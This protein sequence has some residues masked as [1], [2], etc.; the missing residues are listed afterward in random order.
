MIAPKSIVFTDWDG[1]V[2]LQDSNDLVTDL[3]GFGKEERGRLF[4]LM[5]DEK[6]SF[7]E[8]F[9]R[10][11]K[12]IS[13]N[14]YSVDYC[15]EV[16]LKNVKLDPGFKPFLMWCKSNEVPLYVISSGMEP[17]INALLQK[18]IGE[19]ADYIEI[20]ANDVKTDPNDKAK[21]DI[22]YRDETPFGHDKS[23]SI[24]K[25]LSTYGDNR[26]SAFYCGDGISD[27]S[28][29]K[30]CD[31]LFA[32]SGKDLTVFCDRHSIPYRE[33]HTFDDV[34][35]DIAAVTSGEKSVEDLVEGK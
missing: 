30:T 16:L 6:M 7:R 3:L 31:I 13:D 11:L 18:L 4:E 1:T 21:W 22:V 19:E 9:L 29:S 10:M 20:L 32:R 25:I 8:G 27:L 15:I 2:T 24:N 28:A 14:G 33:F 12:S 17:I 34:T 35:R 23:R 5:L 26:P